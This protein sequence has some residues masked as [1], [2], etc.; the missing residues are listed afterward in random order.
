MLFRSQVICKTKDS[1]YIQSNNKFFYVNGKKTKELKNVKGICYDELSDKIYAY[2][3]E[4]VYEV[5]N[6]NMK[7]LKEDFN[8][9]IYVY[10]TIYR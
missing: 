7:K 8:K 3:R 9:I 1:L 2:T 10:L 4:Q 6:G 5:K